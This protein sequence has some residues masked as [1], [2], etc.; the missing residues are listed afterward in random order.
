MDG[1]GEE[2]GA[3]RGCCWYWCGCRSVFS[4]VNTSDGRNGNA[5]SCVDAVARRIWRYGRVDNRIFEDRKVTSVVTF[6]RLPF[7]CF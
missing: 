5:T 7:R 2:D 6:L 3:M 1:G 4:V